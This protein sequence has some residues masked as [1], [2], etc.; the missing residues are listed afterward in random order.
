MLIDTGLDYRTYVVVFVV[1]QN[2]VHLHS[3]QPTSLVTPS[4][5]DI[6][7]RIAATTK[8]EGGEVETADEVDTVGMT[9]HAKIEAS[10]AIAGQTV[11]AALE[12]NG[13]RLVVGHDGRNN[14]LEDGLVGLIGDAIAK[15]KVDSVI[16]AD[17][18][19]NV[20]QL[21]CSREVLAILVEGNSHDTVG[22]IESLFDAIAVVDVN[23]DVEYA[24]LESKEF[25][26]SQDNV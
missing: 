12:H 14:R 19:S 22:S 7:H 16:L 9:T 13:I 6:P 1:G 11:S 5:R 15:R 3:D 8:N 17:T 20:P 23:V 4:A 26:N 24:L 18:D 21:A 25:E 10:Q 2:R